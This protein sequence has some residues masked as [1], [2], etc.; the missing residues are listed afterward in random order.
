VQILEQIGSAGGFPQI[1]EI[2]YNTFVT[3]HTVLAYFARSSLQVKPR[4]WR[5]RLIAQ[6]TCFRARMCPLEA[7]KGVTPF[8]ENIPQTPEKCASMGNFM[9]KRQNLKIALSQSN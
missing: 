6:T 3:L 7:R 9:P 5:T 1:R 4:H 2:A 8:G